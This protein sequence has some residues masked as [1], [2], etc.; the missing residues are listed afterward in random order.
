M[1]PR[2]Q[3]WFTSV[4]GDIRTELVSKIQY[5]PTS[6]IYIDSTDLLLHMINLYYCKY[7]RFSMFI[8]SSRAGR[9]THSLLQFSPQGTTITLNFCLIFI[10]FESH[11]NLGGLKHILS[12]EKKL[13]YLPLVYSLTDWLTHSLIDSL[14]HLSAYYFINLAKVKK[15]TLT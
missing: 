10:I 6:Y 7:C 8:A 14:T 1:R 9:H 11:R 12:F 3:G 5:I 13:I 15:Y 2:T 4:I